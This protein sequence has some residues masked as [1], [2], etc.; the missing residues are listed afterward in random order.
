[1]VGRVFRPY[2]SVR[3]PYTHYSLLSYDELLIALVEIEGTLNTRQ[4]TYSYDV[5]E[6]EVLT[7]SYLLHGRRLRF[8]PDVVVEEDE[9]KESDYSKRFKYLSL[10]LAH[11]WSRWRREYLADLR[12]HHRASCCQEQDQQ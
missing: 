9:E 7:P 6:A 5:L 1:M 12:E 4:L 3:K 2:G 8:I 10:K 11:F